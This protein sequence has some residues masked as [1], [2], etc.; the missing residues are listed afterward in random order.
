[1]RIRLEAV[2][3]TSVIILH[4]RAIQINKSHVKLRQLTRD[5]SNNDD[6]DENDVKQLTIT[7]LELTKE[8]LVI[9]LEVTIEAGTELELSMWFVGRHETSQTGFWRKIPGFFHSSKTV[10][11]E[12]FEGTG[13]QT[14]WKIGQKRPTVRVSER[15]SK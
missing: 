2:K 1:M 4:A 7:S 3:D 12:K 9:K 5:G 11:G 6:D 15:V 10:G 13:I 8:H 14:K